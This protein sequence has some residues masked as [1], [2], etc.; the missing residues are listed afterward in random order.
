VTTPEQVQRAQ[1]FMVE[2]LNSG[3]VFVGCFAGPMKIGDII[4]RFVCPYRDHDGRLQSA[5]VVHPFH[6]TAERTY[7]EFRANVPPEVP[8][9]WLP[10]ADYAAAAGL[11]FYELTTD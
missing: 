5:V 9:I 3:R 2:H 8:E 6:I 4:E 10:S 7:T 11:R 1:A